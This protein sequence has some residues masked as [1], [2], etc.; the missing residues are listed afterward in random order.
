MKYDSWH[1][2]L[3]YEAIF[4][5]QKWLA[6]FKASQTFKQLIV[7][8]NTFAFIYSRAILY[9]VVTDNLLCDFVFIGQ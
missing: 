8:L 5:H 1:C 3:F 9:R 2:T 4:V 7:F 6:L